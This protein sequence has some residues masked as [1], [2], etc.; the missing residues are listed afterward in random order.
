MAKFYNSSIVSFSEQASVGGEV[1]LDLTLIDCGIDGD[2]F[3]PP[4]EGTPSLFSYENHEFFGILDRYTRSDSTSA[5]PQY[6][7]QLSN[8]IFLLEG[9]QLVLNDYY[10]ITNA[11][12]NLLNVFGYLENSG[13][14][15]A[16]QI[17]EAGISWFSVA[18]AVNS[19]INNSGG[20]SYG[21]PI[22]HKGFKYS[23]DLSELPTL[24]NYYRINSTSSSLLGFI[25]EV[26]EAGGHDFFIT[27]NEPVLSGFD[28]H[29]KVV[30][31]SRLT[32]PSGGAI[33]NFIDSVT[34]VTS[35]ELGRELRKDPTS[36]MVVGAPLERIWLVEPDTSGS[37]ANG[38]SSEEYTGYNVLPYFGMDVS[39]NYI[40]GYTNEGEPDEYYFNVDIRDINHPELGAEYL[41]CYGEIKAARTG[42]ESWERYLASRAANKYLILPE[43]SCGAGTVTARPFVIPLNTGWQRYYKYDMNGTGEYE[44]SGEVVYQCIPKWSYLESVKN[45]N[46]GLIPAGFNWGNYFHAANSGFCPDS[47]NTS[48]CAVNSHFFGPSKY[49]YNLYYPS[50]EV[51]NPYFGRA[52]KIRTVSHYTIP[53]SRMFESNLYLLT[54]SGNPNVLSEDDRGFFQSLYTNFKSSFGTDQYQ[55]AATNYYNM[56]LSNRFKF[57]EGYYQEKANRLY[58]KIKDLGDN[59]YGKRYMVTIPTI[60]AA[61]EPESTTIRL[62]QQPI[63]AGYLDSSIWDDAYA[64]GI[65][66]ELSGLNILLSPEEKFYPFIKI[67]NAIA[68]T[69]VQPVGI[70]YN[71]SEISPNERVLGQ[72]TVV[73]GVTYY[74]LWVKTSVWDQIIYRDNTTLL[75]PRVVVELPGIITHDPLGN[76]GSIQALYSDL[77]GIAKESG[78][79]F[80]SDTGFDNTALSAIVNKPGIDE[81]RLHTASI[82]VLPDLFAVPLKSNLL[83]YGPWYLAGAEGPVIYEKNDDLA[84]WNYG[85]F[86]GMDL[87]GF[88]R[89]TDGVT[90]QT[91]DETGSVTVLGVPT[92]GI[93]NQLIAGGPYVTDINVGVSN[94]EVTTQ[95]SF[96]T[97]SSQRRL[98]KLTN[99]QGERIKRLNQTSRDLRRSFREGL[100][101][102]LWRNPL[103][104]FNDI[105]GKFVNLED[106]ARRDNS[107][108][109]HRVMFGDAG[110][111]V[112][113]P[114]YNVMSQSQADNENKAVMSLEGLFRPYSLWPHEN[115]PSFTMPTSTGTPDTS[116]GLNPLKLGHDITI[117]TNSSGGQL[118]SAGSDGGNPEVEIDESGVPDYRGIGF[119]GP[120][121]VVGPGLDI[122]GDPV[123]LYVDSSGEAILDHN[124]KKQWARDYLRNPSSWPAGPVD[125]RWDPSRGVWAAGGTNTKIYLSKV[126]NTYNPPNFSYEVERSRTRAQFSRLGP[127]TLRPYN[128]GE[129]T[130]YDPEYLAYS[131]NPLNTGTYEQLDF[132]GLEFPHYEAF[133]IRETIDDVGNDYYNIWTEDCQDC[134]HLSN[135]CSSGYGAHGSS[136]VGRKILIENPLRQNLGVGDLCFTVKTG[137]TRSINTGS[138]IDGSGADAS[139]YISVNSSGNGSFV[140][141]A[142]GSGYSSGGFGIVNGDVCLSVALEF[143]GGFLISGIVSPSGD[144]PPSETYSVTIYPANATVETESLDIHWI[145]QAEFKSTQVITYVGCENG[146]LQTCSI[147]IQSEGMQTCEYCGADDVGLGSF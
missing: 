132:T 55:A 90:D 84:P 69:G 28:G 67:N 116:I 32:E 70:P 59:Y 52:F 127:N 50:S 129:T 64:S 136:A 39:G 130:I 133:I 120:I 9:T 4:M 146:V 138:F 75:V 95:Y 63:D 99:F 1:A 47:Y 110:T 76:H 91:F 21:G 105:R 14:F 81:L 35:K 73:S 24:P 85:G 106:Y 51:E 144:L 37:I 77:V 107:N 88:A 123:P 7:V 6:T 16:S 122:N 78:G 30:A 83:T 22:L 100:A 98:S 18:S 34:C 25:E 101:N 126:T 145:M 5:Y 71:Y 42:R 112:S 137:R 43:A 86:A 89:V 72:P 36:K 33:Q 20:T 19:M 3:S 62:S 54:E 113:Q 82:P 102:N 56:D 31:V 15:G 49:L 118:T 45:Q 143:S 40:V 124:G 58:K 142:A 131:G 65:I 2:S 68:Y 23:I 104:F 103:D 93:A 97:W 119:K 115:L 92:V 27:L 94:G 147:K 46:A 10:G 117:L 128:S 79:A 8:G 141:G 80:V 96:Q 29:F 108:T 74:D 140:V 121:V 114:V 125:L 57:V 12:P 53:Y 134:G 66:P 17:N 11:V 38:I 41:T 13:G 48:T 26:C 87:A 61:V 139:G 60:L 111:V 135:P 44:P 109:S